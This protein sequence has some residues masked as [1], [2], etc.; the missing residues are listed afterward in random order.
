MLLSIDHIENSQTFKNVSFE[1]L[2]DHCLLLTDISFTRTD[3]FYP[4]C[5]WRMLNAFSNPP[6]EIGVYVKE[7]NAQEISLF[8]SAEQYTSFSFSE[9]KVMYGNPIFDT[10]IF[11]EKLDTVDEDESLYVC[12]QKNTLLCS[13]G[14]I[15]HTSDVI[16][17]GQ[18]GFWISDQ[19]TLCG[20]SIYN[21]SRSDMQAVNH[22]QTT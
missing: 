4:L 9:S 19:K 7:H 5:Y 8:I 16:R 1:V 12:A 18:I 14:S 21:L 15:R 17:N 2:C 13:F 6:S 20:L 11:T 10:S 22:I 3:P